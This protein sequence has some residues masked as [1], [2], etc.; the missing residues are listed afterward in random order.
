MLPLW[1]VLCLDKILS[2][3]CP[4]NLL[5]LMSHTSRGCQAGDADLKGA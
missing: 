5:V 3:A 4:P 1:P 2:A